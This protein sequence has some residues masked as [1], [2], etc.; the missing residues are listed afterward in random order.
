MTASTP[1]REDRKTTRQ[2]RAGVAPAFTLRPE[3]E[4]DTP[5]RL[6]LFR[7]SRGAIWDHVQLPPETLTLIM[8]QQFS[9][10]TQGHGA[11]YPAARLEIIMMDGVPAGRLATDRGPL[12]LHVIDIALTPERRGQGVGEA[13]LRALMSEAAALGVPLALHVARDNVAAHRLYHRLGFGVLSADEAY[14]AL[15]WP[16]PPAQA[17]G[18]A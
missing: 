7:A 10:Q 3:T 4:A 17:A 5:F 11:A 15:R 1:E 18:A 6:A 2:E 9:A 16:P 13:I 8:E 12:S 14:L